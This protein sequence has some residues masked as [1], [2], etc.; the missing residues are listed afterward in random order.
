MDRFTWMIYGA[1]GYTGRLV[2]EEATRRGLTP[3]LAGRNGDAISRLGNRLNL[4]TRVFALDR[5]EAV[6][7]HLSGVHL[8]LHCAGPFSATSAPMLAGCV[9]TGTHYLDITGE[10]DVFESCHARNDAWV[11]AS[12]AVI[13]G[14]GMDVV[15]T[16]C[17]AAIMHDAMPSANRLVLGLRSHGATLSPGTA[18]TAIE[19]LPHGCRVREQGALVSIPAAART[20]AIPFATAPEPAVIMPWG[21]VATAYYTTGIPNIEV[22]FAMPADA[23]R[24]MRR[25]ARV[26]WLA[27]FRAVQMLLKRVVTARIVGPRDDQ[28]AAGEVLIYGEVM[29][30]DGDSLIKRL[31]IPEGYSFTVDAALG[32]VDHMLSET[33]TPGY[34]TPAQCFGSGFV[35]QLQGVTLLD[36]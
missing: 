12:I 22:Y 10:I 9:R 24:M 28:R 11:D 4:D 20:R 23:I 21:D 36:A 27:R 30:D 1:N 2:A 19:G 6:A 34:F 33:A 3:I 25:V 35:F 5:V 8:V 32:A 13:P 29:N 15:P 18:K 31:R 7:E 14:V 17:L 16:D 26:A